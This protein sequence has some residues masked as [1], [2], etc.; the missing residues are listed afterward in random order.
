MQTQSAA[1]RPSASDC[2]AMPSD[3]A[4]GAVIGRHDGFDVTLRKHV[5]LAFVRGSEAAEA[6]RII[7]A[8]AEYPAVDS[9]SKRAVRSFSSCAKRQCASARRSSGSGLSVK[10]G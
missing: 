6:P 5:Y 7:T 1:D 10:I 8:A 2:L 9:R 4:L 3:D